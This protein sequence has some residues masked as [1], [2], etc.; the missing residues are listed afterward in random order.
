MNR[1]IS[2]WSFALIAP[3]IAL[4][5][6]Y[7]LLVR[8]P[9][10]LKEHG[11]TKVTASE[12]DKRAKH[13]LSTR[14]IPAGAVKHLRSQASPITIPDADVPKLQEIFKTYYIKYLTKQFDAIR[15]N[16]G[17]DGRIEI[18][19]PANPS[20]GSEVLADYM[21]AIRGYLGGRDAELENAMRELFEGYTEQ[22]GQN[23]VTYTLS[24]RASSSTQFNYTREVTMLDKDT[25]KIT[26]TGITYGIF[27]TTSNADPLVSA[28]I[29]ELFPDKS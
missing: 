16:L 8:A 17:K 5:L 6:Y 12:T 15:V 18:E 13:V 1:K 27:D 21:G 7:L 9:S 4:A 20:L 29:R 19:V 2:I 10:K 25:G 22:A 24:P 11:Q 23:A 3:L 26:G 14:N 28:T